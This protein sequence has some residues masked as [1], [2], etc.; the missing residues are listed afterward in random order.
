M[1][2]AKKAISPISS[3]EPPELGRKGKNPPFWNPGRRLEGTLLLGGGR[4]EEL[5]LYSGY[6]KYMNSLR[7]KKKE[8]VFFFLFGFR[9]M[10]GG[11]LHLIA[12]EE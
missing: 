2:S 8:Y 3:S 10:G 5:L 6:E 11:T 4:E 12:A 1:L 9:K 7:T